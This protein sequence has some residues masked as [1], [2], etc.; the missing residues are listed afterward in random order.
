V[1]EEEV[2]ARVVLPYL[3][4]LGLNPSEL[5]LETTFVVR[6]GR[7]NIKI[8]GSKDVARGRL[9]ILVRRNGDPQIVIETKTG[10]AIFSESDR[11]QAVSYARLLHPMAPWALW[12]NGSGWRLFDTVTK[13]EVQPDEYEIRDGYKIA[14]PDAERE[15]A[16]ELFLGYSKANLLRFCKHQVASHLRPLQGSAKELSKKYIP[17]LTTNRESVTSA[18]RAFEKVSVPGF[19]LLGESGSGKTTAL[20]EYAN[21][22][23]AEGKVTLFFAGGELEGRLHGAVL[24]ELNWTFT[25]QASIATIVK[26]ISGLA[27]NTP[28]VVVVDAVDEWAYDRKAQ[29]LL[30][31]LRAAEGLNV[32]IVFSCKSGAWERFSCPRGCDLGFAS[33]LDCTNEQGRFVVP[34]LSRRELNDAI[35]RYRGVYNIRFGFEDRLLEEAQR[36]PFLLRIAFAVAAETGEKTLTF[37]TLQLF[38]Q[39]FDAA[40]RK[41]GPS[42]AIVEAQLVAIAQSLD[43]RNVQCVQDKHVRDDLAIP[44]DAELRPEL[45]DHNLLLRTADGIT[46]YFQQLRDYLIAFHVH[47]WQD[48]APKDLATVPFS[49]VRG[50]ALAFYMR[51]ASEEQIRALTG[52][53]YTNAEQYLE[54]Y[55]EVLGKHFPALRSEFQPFTDGEIGFLADFVAPPG[56]LGMYGFR[57]KKVGEPRVRLIPVEQ[58][59]NKSNLREFYGAKGMHFCSSA[60]GFTTMNLRQEVIENEIERQLESIVKER[61]LNLSGC[62]KLTQEALIKSLWSDHYFLPDLFCERPTKIKTPLSGHA[63]ETALKK[64]KLR[65]FFRDQ[66]VEEQKKKQASGAQITG[67]VI[68]RDDRQWIEAQVNSALNSGFEPSTNVILTNEVDMRRKLNRLGAL[69][70][71]FAMNQLPW[72]L[73]WSWYSEHRWNSDPLQQQLLNHLQELLEAFLIEYATV[74]EQNFPKLTK[75]FQLYNNMPVRLLAAEHPTPLSPGNEFPHL[76]VLVAERSPEGSDNRVQ[77]TNIGELFVDGQR[78]EYRGE[79]VDCCWMMMASM[80][81]LVYSS[82]NNSPLHYLVYRRLESELPAALN[83]LRV[84]HELPYSNNGVLPANASQP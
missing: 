15:A 47:R 7:S 48:S 21:R 80:D 9:D 16:A 28:F 13:N 66:V 41:T 2:K 4:R 78:V 65:G 25:E 20:C 69:H 44:I 55:S 56:H 51:F 10:G 1:N 19:L 14:F 38:E 32:K 71:G 64:A 49:G 50:E 12:T 81:D 31:L 53:I 59:W 26:R 3:E 40:V 36:N 11:D 73:A 24:E 72:Q 45:F 6:I 57:E 54:L 58:V 30:G 70:P 77:L 42:R 17:E 35:K 75:G 84:E 52:S 82:E 39:Y 43:E 22:R 61:N 23:L 5:S 29:N 76:V 33:L 8:D 60:N 63:M 83:L 46:F 74:I 62:P 68:D 79:A 37:S 27:G 67:G 18:L 34:P